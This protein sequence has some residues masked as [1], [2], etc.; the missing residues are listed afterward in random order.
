MFLPNDAFNIL[1]GFGVRNGRF[2][3]WPFSEDFMIEF[4]SNCS[5]VFK[6]LPLKDTMDIDEKKTITNID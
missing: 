4:K 3:F 5:G 6:Q 2:H 1:L